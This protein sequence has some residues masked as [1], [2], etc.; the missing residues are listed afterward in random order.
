MKLK[1]VASFLLSLSLALQ[2][3]TSCSTPDPTI[4]VVGDSL[5]AQSG[6]K[7]EAYGKSKGFA[8]V[9]E[10]C[11]GST[12][13]DWADQVT[14]LIDKHHPE[15]VVLALGSNNAV[16]PYYDLDKYEPFLNQPPFHTQVEDMIRKLGPPLDCYTWVEP[17]T[18]PHPSDPDGSIAAANV[19]SFREIVPE[20]NRIGWNARRSQEPAPGEW[21]APD[22][23]HLTGAGKSIYAEM[24]IDSTIRK[25]DL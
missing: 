5:I 3:L 12:I 19:D 22:G 6:P 2:L 13:E 18:N 25:C 24:I 8:V 21:I 15:A 23:L 16:D 9:V 14:T 7:L 20:S 1:H 17:T 4:L 11:C 10:S